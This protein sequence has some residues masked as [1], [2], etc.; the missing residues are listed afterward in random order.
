[1]KI[2]LKLLQKPFA[3]FVLMLFLISV[4]P[5][6]FADSDGVAGVDVE[7][8]D[9][10]N[11]NGLE[12][13]DGDEVENDDELEAEDDGDGNK[14]ELERKVRARELKEKGIKIKERVEKSKEDMERARER[15]IEAKDSYG[16]AKEKF[17]NDKEALF[18]LRDQVKECQ[19]DGDCE[20]KK[21]NL[22]NGVNKH[23]VKTIELIE[24]SL[25]KLVNKVSESELDD[26]TKE[27]ALTQIAE[28]E[29]KLSAEKVEVEALA[30]GG[31]AEELRNAIK[32]MKKT[33]QDT[34][35]IQK[36][37]VASLTHSK[38]GD[39]VEKH[40]G[41]VRSMDAKIE[42]LEKKG[43]DVSELVEIRERFSA[44]VSEIEA[45]YDAAKE[46]WKAAENKQEASEAWRIAQ[47]KVRESMKESREILLKFAIKFVEIK[48][49]LEETEEAEESE[50]DKSEDSGT[51]VEEEEE[52][53]DEQK[54]EEGET[55]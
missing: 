39:L 31:S 49:S 42:N 1:M 53:E 35:H 46:E 40:I 2:K 41:L 43:A 23:L 36:R 55:T 28:L 52:S 45:E 54:L 47:A 37:I 20:L 10:D 25:E 27:N 7:D 44:K 29:A 34:R 22:R 26:E 17:E 21:F 14:N 24:K 19:K 48:K 30:D 4:A 6:A 12:A 15:F 33:W 16:E 32:A 9:D 11:E 13:N 38:L 8:S 50:T 3:L 18:K 5:V 51:E